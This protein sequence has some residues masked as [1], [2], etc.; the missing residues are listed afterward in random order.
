[1]QPWY[2]SWALPFAALYTTK[3]WLYFSGAVFL[4]YY[5]YTLPEISPGFWPEQLWVK[6]VEYVPFF[7]LLIR[8]F[9]VREFEGC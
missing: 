2:L 5:T 4:S 3:P 9:K 1:V 6:V 8:S 7:Y